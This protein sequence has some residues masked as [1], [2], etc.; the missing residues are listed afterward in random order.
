M[1]GLAE[2]ERLTREQ[3]DFS[4]F[5]ESHLHRA[6]REDDWGLIKSRERLRDATMAALAGEARGPIHVV[7]DLGGMIVFETAAGWRGHRWARREGE[8][9]LAETLVIDGAARAVA[10]GR[11]VR[12]EAARIGGAGPVHAPLG[13]LRPARGQLATP[14][15]PPLPPDFPAPAVPAACHLHRLWNARALNGAIDA[16]TGPSDAQDGQAAWVLALLAAL[17]DA[18]LL[19]ERAIVQGDD[20]ALLWR[21]HGHYLGAGFDAAARGQRVR[22]IG[23]SVMTVENGRVVTETTLLDTLSIA[24]Q[25]H[26]PV[27][28]YA[29]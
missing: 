23:S 19:I 28:D 12:R 6:T 13:E 1:I 20:I 4:V 9:V 15:A 8:R 5:E 16:W 2:I 17:P 29:G 18:I 27:I 25:L 26:R 21:L 10:L 14:G 7:A 3:R 11:D 22:A 24:A